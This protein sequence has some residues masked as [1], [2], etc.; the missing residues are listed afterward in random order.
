MYISR[1]VG[2]HRVH[3]QGGHA[4]HIGHHAQL[5][6]TLD[7]VGTHGAV[8]AAGGDNHLCLNHIG[9]HAGLGVVVEGHKG[10]V[11]HNTTHVLAATHVSILTDDQVLCKYSNNTGY[12]VST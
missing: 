11:G 8:V 1:Q 12:D 3:V 6:Q 5:G 2:T 9:V 10:P 7:G 4:G